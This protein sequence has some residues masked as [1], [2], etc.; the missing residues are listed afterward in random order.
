MDGDHGQSGRAVRVFLSALWF[1]LLCL[2]MAGHAQTRTPEDEYKD[3]IRVSQDIQPLGEHPFGAKIGLYDGS[4]SFQQTDVSLA[5]NGPLLQLSRTFEIEGSDGSGGRWDMALGDCDIA[6]P[7]IET[8]TAKGWFYSSADGWQQADGWQVNA[9][10]THL[11]C[12]N[13]TKPLT[14]SA[15]R[16]VSGVMPWEPVTWWHGYH[17][18][19]PGHGSH[20]LLS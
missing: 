2:P 9:G 8:L 16:N 1:L 11:R 13:F 14:V 20:D 3:L 15:M 10:N 18:V 6:L 12:A 17:L 7:R 4:L 19:V 5:G